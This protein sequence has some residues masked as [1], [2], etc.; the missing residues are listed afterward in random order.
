MEDLLEK[1]PSNQSS[2]GTTP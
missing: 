1:Q 2:G